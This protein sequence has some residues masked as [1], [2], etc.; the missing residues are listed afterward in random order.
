M[1]TMIVLSE[2]KVNDHAGEHYDSI[3]EVEDQPTTDSIQEWGNRIRD[4]IRGLWNQDLSDKEREGEPV[5]SVTLDAASPYNAMLVNL[6]IMMK[7]EEGVV[8]D[9]PY[10]DA[11]RVPKSRDARKAIEKLDSR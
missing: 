1:K 6:Q 10:L 5:V 3:L 9:L 4:R 2:R 8:I 11:E 7:E